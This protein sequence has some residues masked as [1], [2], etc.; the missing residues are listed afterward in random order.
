MW[1]Q[2]VLKKSY[3][4]VF[5]FILSLSKIKNKRICNLCGNT[6]EHYTIYRI[7]T[8]LVDCYKRKSG[9]PYRLCSFICPNV[10]N[11]TISMFWRFRIPE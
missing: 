9:I 10:S 5:L 6:L 8:A 4:A 2:S 1:N 11:I 7:L 3:I